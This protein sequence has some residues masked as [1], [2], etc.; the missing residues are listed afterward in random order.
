MIIFSIF[1]LHSIKQIEDW[2]QSLLMMQR[3]QHIC[4]TILQKKLLISEA[5]SLVTMTEVKTKV[6]RDHSNIT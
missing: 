1:P 2:A 3:S 5:S 4:R 6:Q